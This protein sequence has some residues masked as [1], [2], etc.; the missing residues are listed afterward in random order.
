MVT[1][2]NVDTPALEMSKAEER[3][4]S[5]ASDMDEKK[6]MRTVLEH[7]NETVDKGRMLSDAINQ[8]FSSFVPDMMFDNLVKNFSTTRNIYGDRLLRLVTGY[9]AD[10]LKKNIR[11][12]EFQRELK[13]AIHKSIDGL[14][15]EGLLSK[16]GAIKD[17]GI[18]LASLIMYAEELDNLIPKG[19]SGEK[20][21]YQMSHYGTKT[22]SKDYRKGDRFK[23]IDIR[24]TLRRAIQRGRKQLNAADL[25]V[26]QR[27]RKGSVTIVYGIDASGS[28]KGTK[29]ESAKKAGI[30]LAF[31]AI[32]RKDKV[33]LIVFGTTVEARVDPT[34]DFMKLLKEIV[35]TKAIRETNITDT[36]KEAI[37]MF[38]RDDSTKHIVL[39]TDAVPTIGKNPE[40]ETIKAV[41]IARD[42]GISVSLIGIGLDEKG[43]ALAERIVEVSHGRLYVIR[44]T[45]EAD[46]VILEDYYSL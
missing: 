14:K 17:K 41:S 26:S 45:G 12:P 11:I 1:P 15:E 29:I 18:L 2:E 35:R 44:D 33:G 6:L 23:D 43:K 42:A 34:D 22:E 39:I 38:P 9:S 32:E 28:M 27:I 8:G 3:K 31:K 30:A 21:S 36:I 10:Y 19:F 20:R 13:D 40:K 24:K 7:D 4:G 16:G 5:L 37:E 46:K 25:K